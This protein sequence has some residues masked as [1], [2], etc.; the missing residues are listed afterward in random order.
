M[1]EVKRRKQEERLIEEQKMKDLRENNPQTYLQQ[2]K[3]KYKNLSE[4]AKENERI[5]NE[6]NSR[7]SRLKQK[8]MQVLARLAEEDYDENNVEN[9]EDMQALK[10]PEESDHYSELEVMEAEL[11]EIDPEW[12]SSKKDIHH[13]NSSNQLFMSVELVKCH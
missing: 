9:E 5:K 8:R 10:D 6:L 2:L 7:K 13:L 4:K 11:R 3:E 12:N 1:I